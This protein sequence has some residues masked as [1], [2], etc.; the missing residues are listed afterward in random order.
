MTITSQIFFHNIALQ[1]HYLQT[2]ELWR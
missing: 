2:G 1:F